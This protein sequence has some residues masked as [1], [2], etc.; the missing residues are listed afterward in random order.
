MNSSSQIIFC[1]YSFS[2][3]ELIATHDFPWIVKFVIFLNKRSN[4]ILSLSLLKLPHF[5]FFLCWGFVIGPMAFPQHYILK[6]ILFT[7]NCHRK[8]AYCCMCSSFMFYDNLFL[9]F[10]SLYNNVEPP[11]F[12]LTHLLNRFQNC[13]KPF[14][15]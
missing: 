5:L 12:I 13:S 3:V 6:K 10:P 8:I 4:L 2:T 7:P 11:L 14:V 9:F 15:Y 1:S